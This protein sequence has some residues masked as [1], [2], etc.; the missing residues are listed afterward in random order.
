MSGLFEKFISAVDA[1]SV[2]GVILVLGGMIWMTEL[3][4][5]TQASAETLAQ[6]RAGLQEMQIKFEANKGEIQKEVY[7]QLKEMNERLS[8]IEGKLL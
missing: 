8:R 7:V 1:M 3:H 2:S 5:T 4:L 6:V